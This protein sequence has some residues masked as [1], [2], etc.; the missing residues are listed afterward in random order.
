M[1]RQSR[2]SDKPSSRP[3]TT[4]ARSEE[5][6]SE[7]QSLTNLVCRLLLEKKKASHERLVALYGAVVSR[8]YARE[9]AALDAA[10]NKTGGLKYEFGTTCVVQSRSTGQPSLYTPA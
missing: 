7:L 3:G 9:A 2:T 5:H 10:L 6:T 8:L 1:N 4:P